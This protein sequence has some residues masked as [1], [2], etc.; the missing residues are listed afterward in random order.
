MILAASESIPHVWRSHF[1]EAI[2]DRL[3]S[4]TPPTDDEVH[5]AIHFVSNR[6]GV[7]VEVA[8]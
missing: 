8:P 6:M 2:A 4:L 5:E 3:L 1:M 7:N